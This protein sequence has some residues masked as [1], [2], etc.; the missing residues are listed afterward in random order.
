[1]ESM[2]FKSLTTSP[3]DGIISNGWCVLASV[4]FGLDTRSATTLL[5]PDTIIDLG[6]D[7]HLL[8]TRLDS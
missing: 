6:H 8:Q 4:S 1:M 2:G 3:K 7:P 5:H